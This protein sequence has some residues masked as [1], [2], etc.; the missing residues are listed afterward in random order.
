MS[1]KLY[2]N[3]SKQPLNVIGVGVIEPGEH[4]S[5]TTEYQPT[6]ILANYP[7]LVDATDEPGPDSDSVPTPEQPADADKENQGE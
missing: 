7:G 2:R 4:I 1:T 3:T 5:V 6:V